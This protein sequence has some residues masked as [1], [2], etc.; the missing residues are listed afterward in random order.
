VFCGL[1]MRAFSVWLC[2]MPQAD[3]SGDVDAMLENR[4]SV[5]PPLALC[6]AKY[7]FA[8]FAGLLTN[9]TSTAVSACIV[10]VES[11]HYHRF[12]LKTNNFVLIISYLV[13]LNLR[14]LI[15]KP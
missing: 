8:I 1:L 12:T 9:V 7:L 13:C 5:Q 2:I 15:G 3:A 11:Y 14:L 4:C 10:K 6:K